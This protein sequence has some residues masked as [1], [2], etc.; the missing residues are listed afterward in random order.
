MHQAPT[1]TAVSEPSAQQNS[2]SMPTPMAVSAPI[3]L[4]R[5]A[6]ASRVRAHWEAN[7]P[8]AKP[9]NRPATGITK[10]PTAAPATPHRIG[11]RVTRSRRS[12]RPVSTADALSPAT[13]RPAAMTPNVQDA[14]EPS[15]AA[16]P[17]AVTRLS[18]EPGRTGYTVPT[19][20]TR[21]RSTATREISAGVTAPV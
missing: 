4:L 14:G 17:R 3:E 13:A 1:P 21:S 11:P 16:Q 18:S 2:T 19:S 12:R 8:T 20:P 15:S 10:N 9:R 5:A 7:R 6:R